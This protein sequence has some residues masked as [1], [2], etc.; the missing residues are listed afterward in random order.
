[1]AED[2]APEPVTTSGPPIGAMVA[3]NRLDLLQTGEERLAAILALIAGAKHSLKLLFYMF[4]TDEVGVQVRDAL[5]EA[6]RRGVEVKLLIDGFGSTAEPKFFTVLDESGGQ[7]C[8][9]N[10]TYGRR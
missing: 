9:F 7:H 10:P 5:V 4:N 6:A 3:G 2:A 1:M 8:V